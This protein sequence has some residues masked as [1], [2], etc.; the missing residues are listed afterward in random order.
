M[1]VVLYNENSPLHSTWSKQFVDDDKLNRKRVGMN[2]ARSAVQLV[3]LISDAA[4]DAKGG[5]HLIFAVGHGGT[6]AEA[7]DQS[8]ADGMVDLAPNK[9]LRLST[10]GPGNFV[11]PFY[12]YVFPAHAGL[13][14]RSDKDQD[15]KMH[16][17][18]YK[19]H[20]ANWQLYQN[21]GTAIRTNNVGKVTF[22]TCRIG[23]AVNFIKKIAL[24]WHVV[25]HA[26]KKYVW[27]GGDDAGKIRVYLDG[28]KPGA[29]T[30]IPDG[31]TQLP[32]GS[33]VLVGPPL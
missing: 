26:Y 23:N 25:V 2:G 21:I 13:V 31:A 20:L 19:D 3:K 10:G 4:K 24:D 22:L 28:D 9:K 17:A 5:G 33:D 32:K 6:Q 15:E 11:N 27:F 7:T 12:D 8:Y 1:Q 30:N 14:S 18:G 29:G 16:L